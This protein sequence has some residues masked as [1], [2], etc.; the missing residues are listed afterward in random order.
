MYTPETIKKLTTPI[1]A[2]PR[3]FDLKTSEGSSL[4][5]SP[6]I[7]KNG[8]LTCEILKV[9]E[10]IARI[11]ISAGSPGYGTGGSKRD[12][13]TQTLLRLLTLHDLKG[14]R[15]KKRHKD[16]SRLS[17]RR[18]RNSDKKSRNNGYIIFAESSSAIEILT[19]GKLHQIKWDNSSE[20]RCSCSGNRGV[21]EFGSQLFCYRNKD[22]KGSKDRVHMFRLF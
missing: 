18:S 3:V 11:R 6:K 14:C 15:S 10:A 2:P 1:R 21:I 9:P 19:G 20:Y 13:A 16:M 7:Q 4:A 5:S 8:S 22:K 12:D 17:C